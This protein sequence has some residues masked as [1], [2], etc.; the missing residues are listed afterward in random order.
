[1]KK[2]SG[3][4]FILFFVSIGAWAQNGELLREIDRQI[5][6]FG[7]DF[8]GEYTI[9][10]YIPNQGVSEE[11]VAMFRR[12]DDDKFLVLI[13][14]PEIRAGK[15]YLKIGNNMWIYDPESRR[16]N[17]TSARDRF[18]D[19]TV[20]NSDFEPSSLAEDYRVVDSREEQLGAYATRVLEM[21]ATSGS[22][23]FQRRTIW[24]DENNLIRKMED[25]T[26]SGELLRTVVIPQYRRIE[27][28]YVA[29][30]IV[31]VDALRGADVEGRFVNERTVI[32]VAKPSFENLPDVV[33]TQGFLERVGR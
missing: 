21:Q 13:L 26:P 1:M 16:F 19:S 17:V 20:R 18:Q 23:S 12:D 8:S 15:G 27:D 32:A 28:K 25:Y 22:V 5:A 31:F 14:E 11:T 30:N 2:I 9:T 10:R 6:F 7:R 3:I 29:V 33:F 4:C 24:V